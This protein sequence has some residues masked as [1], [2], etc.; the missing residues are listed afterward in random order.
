MHC[1]TIIRPRA[2]TLIEL[3]VVIAI[4]AVLIALLLPAVQK[5]HGSAVAAAKFP[6]LQPVASDVLR[7]TE[8]QSGGIAEIEPPLTRALADA[9]ALIST[10]QDQQQ[11]PDPGDVAAV[12]QEVKAVASALRQ[13]LAALDN[14]ASA[15]IPGEL[16]AYLALK[17]DLQEVVAKLELTS[18]HLTKLNDIADRVFHK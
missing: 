7:L 3:L 10:A 12:L 13:D 8:P 18:V 4:I 6:N 17:H 15:F 9:D 11:V 5:L 14:P 1:K 2:F 16:E